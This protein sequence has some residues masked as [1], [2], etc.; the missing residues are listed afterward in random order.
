MS[1]LAAISDNKES[2]SILLQAKRD[3]R[4]EMISLFSNLHIVWKHLPAEMNDDAKTII[5]KDIVEKGL[6]E[7]NHSS[8][9]LDEQVEVLFKG[10]GA[11]VCAQKQQICNQERYIETLSK[12][13]EILKQQVQALHQTLAQNNTKLNIIKSSLSYLVI[14]IEEDKKRIFSKISIPDIVDKLKYIADT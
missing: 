2:F 3:L 8:A 11:S 12:E 13:C 6:L 1:T 7:L 9:V 5:L 14:E 10:H 4:H